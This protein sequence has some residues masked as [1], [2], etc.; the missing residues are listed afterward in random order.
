M[1][2]KYYIHVKNHVDG[3]SDEFR[4]IYGERVLEKVFPELDLFV[5]PI[6]DG[7][8]KIQGWL[9]SEGKSGAAF[10]P[11]AADTKEKSILLA[12]DL[13]LK[14]GVDRT[15]AKTE[16]MITKHGLSPRYKP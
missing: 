8:G 6:M 4:E 7:I 15:I 14:N 16:K 5:H 10:T 1:K 12:L 13:I 9:V 3:L 2:D 11:T